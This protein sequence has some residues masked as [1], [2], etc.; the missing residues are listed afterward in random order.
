MVGPRERKSCRRIVQDWLSGADGRHH[1]VYGGIAVIS[2]S[3]KAF[4]RF[5]MTQVIFKRL[6]D[7]E[8]DAY[9]SSGEWRGKAGAYGIQG[10]AGSF[11]PWINATTAWFASSDAAENI[12]TY[13]CVH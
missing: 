7:A 5:V 2:S 11:V 12:V 9:I 8:T 6:S 10:H 13:R 1:H 3:G 4:T